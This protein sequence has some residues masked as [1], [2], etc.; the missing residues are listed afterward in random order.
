MIREEVLRAAQILESTG[1]LSKGSFGKL[2][3][4]RDFDGRFKPDVTIDCT[5]DKHMHLYQDGQLGI[6]S[7]VKETPRPRCLCAAG[8]MYL[9]VG[10][11]FYDGCARLAEFLGLEYTN[12]PDEGQHD[13]IDAIAVWNDN[14]TLEEVVKAMREFGR[15]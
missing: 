2:T 12:E 4:F 6:L 3:G 15:Q 11:D 7:Y 8:A 1:K 10:P 9:V 14:S 5:T 13:A